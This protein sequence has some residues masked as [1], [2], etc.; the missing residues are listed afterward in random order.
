MSR[1]KDSQLLILILAEKEPSESGQFQEL[2][3]SI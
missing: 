2:P 3:E 1:E